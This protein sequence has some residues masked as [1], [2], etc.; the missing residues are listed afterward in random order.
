MRARVRVRGVR[1]APEAWGARGRAPDDRDAAW[2]RNADLVR[3][4]GSARYG[5]RPG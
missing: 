3:G 1:A 5:R 2:P 4:G